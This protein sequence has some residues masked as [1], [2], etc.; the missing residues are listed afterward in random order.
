VL[1][2]VV[3]MLLTLG[4][5]ALV[6]AGSAHHR[7]PDATAALVTHGVP[8]AD[9]VGHRH[10]HGNDWAPTLGKRLRPATTVAFA[11]VVP[12]ARLAPGPGLE[13]V[14][15]PARV[16]DPLKTLTVLRV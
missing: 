8:V 3:M 9:T 1:V 10:E 6:S 11:G 16:F 15:S 5:T 2:A 4:A 13:H 14:V 7:H 12:A